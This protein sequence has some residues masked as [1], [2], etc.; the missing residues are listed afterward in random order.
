MN[1]FFK[2]EILYPNDYFNLA[3]QMC[4]GLSCSQAYQTGWL[5]VA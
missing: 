1:S 3:I 2:F 5:D 4:T